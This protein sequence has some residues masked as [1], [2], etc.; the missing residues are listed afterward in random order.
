MSTVI[1]LWV[2][3]VLPQNGDGETV[4]ERGELPCFSQIGGFPNVNE[5]R[6]VLAG[7]LRALTNLSFLF[8]SSPLQVILPASRRHWAMRRH[9]WLSQL[10]GGIVPGVLRLEVRYAAA[11]GANAGGPLT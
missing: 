9:F 7:V 10:G 2:G 6:V 11:T 5:V 3:S 1:P 8:S 4:G